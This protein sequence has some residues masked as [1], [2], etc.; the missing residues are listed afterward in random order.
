MGAALAARPHVAA[1]R[2]VVLRDADACSLFCRDRQRRTRVGLACEA[3]TAL[4]SHE[5]ADDDREAAGRQRW[6][7]PHALVA[8][9]SGPRGA[10][11]TRAG[12]AGITDGPLGGVGREGQ[13][14][15]DHDAL[16]P[17]AVSG[18]PA[19]APARRDRAD[20]RDAGGRA[21]EMPC[22]GRRGRPRR[23]RCAP[24][25]V[26]GSGAVARDRQR[27]VGASGPYTA[28]SKRAASPRRPISRGHSGERSS[29]PRRS[30]LREV[31]RSGARTADLRRS[32]AIR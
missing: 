23:G 19:R 5:N 24:H 28:R 9:T 18:A 11:R 3:G 22:H 10:L 17:R 15:G 31:R 6:R 27:F 13:R 4:G 20:T 1:P 12:A 26:V 30:P 2:C 25:G 32:R 8:S 14:A 7:A 16:T 29:R 21:A